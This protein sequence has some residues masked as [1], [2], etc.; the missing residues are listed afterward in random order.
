MSL[1]PI[2]LWELLSRG[3]HTK[4]LPLSFMPS[5]DRPFHAF[6][7]HFSPSNTISLRFPMSQVVFLS[8]QPLKCIVIPSPFKLSILHS[9]HMS[10]LTRSIISQTLPPQFIPCHT[11]SLTL[12]HFFHHS[13]SSYHILLSKTSFLQP[14]FLASVTYSMA[15]FWLPRLQSWGLCCPLILPSFPY[16]STLHNSIEGPSDSSTV[17]LSS[18]SFL[19]CHQTYPWHLNA[20]N[21]L[22]SSLSPPI[23]ITRLCAISSFSP[24]IY[25]MSFVQF[26]LSPC[27]VLQNLYFHCFLSNTIPILYF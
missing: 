26:L 19:P 2:S 12:A 5:S 20:W 6:F 11:T 1:M 16:T 17:L 27:R 25:N 4:N 9:F 10:K 13:I 23:S 8:H 18:I 3:G 21:S 24:Y 22:T 15:M 7:H 14:G